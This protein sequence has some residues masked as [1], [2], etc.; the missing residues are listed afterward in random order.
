MISGIGTDIARKDRFGENIDKLA[1]RI[2]TNFELAEFNQSTDKISYVAKKW[3]AKEAISKAFGTG[4]TGNTKWKNIEIRHT[5]TGMPFAIFK[6]E[7]Y[8]HCEILNIKCNLSISDE[9]E[10][11][12][13]FALL[14]RQ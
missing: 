13:A 12:V 3:A 6:N 5:G 2:L 7:M 9:S 11:A 10:Y 1:E 8:T 14:E 4:L